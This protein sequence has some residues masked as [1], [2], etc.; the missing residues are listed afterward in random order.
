MEEIVLILSFLSPL[1]IS[2]TRAGLGPRKT[3]VLSLLRPFL[4]LVIGLLAY[5]LIGSGFASDGNEFIGYENFLFL[6]SEDMSI[7]WKVRIR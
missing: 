6:K 2:M 3:F 4:H 5:W 7:L 1:G